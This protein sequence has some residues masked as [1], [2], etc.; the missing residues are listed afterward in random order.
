MCAVDEPNI[1]TRPMEQRDIFPTLA[2]LKKITDARGALTHRDL[3][4]WSLGKERDASF[5][6]EINGQVVGLLLG[7]FTF[8]GIPVSEVC[9]IQVLVVDPDYHRQHIGASLVNALINRCYAE[10]VSTIRAFLPEKNLGLKNFLENTGFKPSGITEY[11][12]TI[13]A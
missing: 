9:S 10:G 4:S 13:E 3:V 5:V 8:L 2:M 11:V 12:R 1:K 6:A 7:R